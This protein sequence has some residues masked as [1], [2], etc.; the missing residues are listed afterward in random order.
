MMGTCVYCPWYFGCRISLF[1]NAEKIPA[2]EH[3]IVQ[4]YLDKPFLIEGYKCDLR[5][6]VLVSSCD[7]L[8]IFLFNDG[9][10]RMGTEQYKDPSPQNLVSRSIQKWNLQLKFLLLIYIYKIYIIILCQ[11]TLWCLACAYLPAALVGGPSIYVG[12]PS[13]YVGGPSFYVGGPAVYYFH[14]CYYFRY[15]IYN[16]GAMHKNP[17]VYIERPNRTRHILVTIFD[18]Q[19]C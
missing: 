5:I 19:L 12:G 6:Y 16:L 9:L 17:L 13:N 7:P 1:H 15:T 11:Y 14:Y 2:T 8:K 18:F 3:T 4:E 10:V